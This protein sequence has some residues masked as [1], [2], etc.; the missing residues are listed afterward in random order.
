MHG[1]TVGFPFVD[2]ARLSGGKTGDVVRGG[3]DFPRIN[4]PLV[5]I[6]MGAY[7]LHVFLFFSFSISFTTVGLIE[8]VVCSLCWN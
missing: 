8:R 6:R 1:P 3:A 7:D 4:A 2:I 5:E